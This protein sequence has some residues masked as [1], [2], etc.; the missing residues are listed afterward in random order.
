MK[1]PAAEL[2]AAL[3]RLKQQPVAPNITFWDVGQDVRENVAIESL[4]FSRLMIG[5]GQKIQVRANLRNFGDANHPD[6]RV[7][8]KVDGKDKAS[9]QI[10]LGVEGATQNGKHHWDVNLSSGYTDNLTIQPANISIRVLNGS[11]IPGRAAE[12]ATAL[13]T[14]G[15]TVVD[16]ND[17]ERSDYTTSEIHHSAPLAEAA[18]TR[19][20]PILMTSATMVFGMAPLALK[21]ESGAESRAPIAIVVIGALISSTALTVLVVPALYTLFDDLSEWSSGLF[22]RR[23]RSAGAVH[24]EREAPPVVG[25]FADG[26]TPDLVAPG[27]EPQPVPPRP[28]RTPGA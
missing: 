15:F 12:V 20:R 7:T 14:E 28:A 8:L 6:L 10:A 25:V 19:L 18:R 27:A 4:D 9:S 1:A 24:G 23:P 17:A 2:V 11:G 26:D 5:V 16:I 21:L 3:D 22:R 13:E